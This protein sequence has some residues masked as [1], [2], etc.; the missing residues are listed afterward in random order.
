MLIAVLSEDVL[1]LLRVFVVEWEYAE[2]GE[3]A[4]S[5]LEDVEVV[6]AVQTAEQDLADLIKEGP[7]HGQGLRLVPLPLVRLGE[8]GEESVA[9][10]GIVG[11]LAELFKLLL[12][13]FLVLGDVILDLEAVLEDHFEALDNLHD[14]VVLGDHQFVRLQRILDALWHLERVDIRARS[15]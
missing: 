8:E 15:R 11:L 6:P 7:L 9:L 4:L 2:S 14:V 10:A 5:H 1:V 3:E 12:L 13:E